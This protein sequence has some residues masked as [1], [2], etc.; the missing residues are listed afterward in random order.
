MNQK[1]DKDELGDLEARLMEKLNEMVK[2]L[3]G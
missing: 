1:V 3:M 2:K